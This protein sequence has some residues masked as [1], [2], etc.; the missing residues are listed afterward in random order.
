MSG[1]TPQKQPENSGLLDRIPHDILSRSV[2]GCLSIK[3]IAF[4]LTP[5]NKHWHEETKDLVNTL[6]DTWF[7][8]Q[9]NELQQKMITSGD[10]ALWHY[11]LS[12]KTPEE[13]FDQYFAEVLEAPHV[14]HQTFANYYIHLY[15]QTIVAR[16]EHIRKDFS[17]RHWTGEIAAILNQL[18]VASRR[19]RTAFNLDTVPRKEIE[20]KNTV[21]DSKT[22]DPRLTPT[23]QQLLSLCKIPP[24]EDG[25]PKTETISALRE[26]QEQVRFLNDQFLE[27]T[28]K[29]LTTAFRETVAAQEV[30]AAYYPDAIRGQI[31]VSYLVSAEGLDLR[32]TP[33]DDDLNAVIGRIMHRLNPKGLAK[34]LSHDALRGC[35]GIL[36]FRELDD[37]SA[38]KYSS[39]LCLREFDSILE[40]F[41]NAELVKMSGSLAEFGKAL[42]QAL[43]DNHPV[44][45]K[46]FTEIEYLA[47]NQTR[48]LLEVA[49]LTFLHHEHILQKLSDDAVITVLKRLYEPEINLPPLLLD[50]KGEETPLARRMTREL[51]MRLEED[52]RLPAIFVGL[53][54]VTRKLSG[55]DIQ[56]LI[57]IR[58]KGTKNLLNNSEGLDRLLAYEPNALSRLKEEYQNNISLTPQPI[59]KNYQEIIESWQHIV[60][61]IES[62]ERT[63]E[64]KIKNQAALQPKPIVDS[65]PS[66][67]DHPPSAA[68]IALHSRL[69]MED[70]A[71][72]PPPI[73]W[74]RYG[75]KIS[76]GLGVVSLLAGLGLLVFES[77][78]LFTPLV[79]GLLSTG[80]GLLLIGTLFYCLN[81]KSTLDRPS[82]NSQSPLISRDTNQNSNYNALSSAAMFPSADLKPNYQSN[83]PMD[84]RG[85]KGSSPSFNPGGL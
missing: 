28:E 19:L 45:L 61:K 50:E 66:V 26:H 71:L 67:F 41:S 5:A 47:L 54:S 43:G 49:P 62:I 8:I 2:L 84:Y 82:P 83:N 22:T 52:H 46:R 32:H 33:Y 34:H 18:F 68:D 69:A 73:Y 36:D 4:S 58:V 80:G 11:L 23:M 27:T 21:A 55:R 72:R 24:Q 48:S 30:M 76:L 75:I 31:A 60:S 10:H 15:T 74:R 20:E 79:I 39:L 59:S 70:D 78:G 14:T 35:L 1:Q 81:S 53:P 77:A 6:P 16:L 63:E 3:N 40:Q 9:K 42:V 37:P 44:L 25:A 7:E 12:S 56:T 65:F 17:L 64:A 57:H 13:G 85:N 38:L 51:W 29:F